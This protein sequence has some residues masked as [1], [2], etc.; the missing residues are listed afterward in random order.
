[1][2]RVLLLCCFQIFDSFLDV[3][4]PLRG[5]L[6]LRKD[7]IWC[8]WLRS[9]QF[10]HKAELI[11]TVFLGLGRD[12]RGG[13]TRLEP[14]VAGCLFWRHALLWIPF[15]AFADEIDER[16]VVAAECLRDGLRA[17]FPLASFGVGYAPWNASRIEKQPP[18]GGSIDEIIWWN[19]QNFHDTR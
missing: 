17:R 9:L 11:I 1:M 19:A 14:L 16:G 15:E 5:S 18:P 2:Q 6:N 10:L 8:H 7:C 4:L 12:V 3:S 13:C